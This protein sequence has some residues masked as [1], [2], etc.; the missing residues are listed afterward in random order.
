MYIRN[1][2]SNDFNVTSNYLKAT[3]FVNVALWNTSP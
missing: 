1:T 3:L 2:I